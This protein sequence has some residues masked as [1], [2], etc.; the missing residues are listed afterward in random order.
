MFVRILALFA[1]LASASVNAKSATPQMVNINKC[2]IIGKY[3][4]CLSLF[5]NCAD[6]GWNSWNKFACDITE[7]LIKATA[8]ALVDTGLA[9]LGYNYVNLDDCWQAS[10]RDSAGFI[11]ADSTRF[12][13]GLKSLGDYIHAKGL[14][15]GIYSSAGFKT[16]Q[17]FPASLGLEEVDA[18]SYAAWGVDY[19]KYD[20]CYQDNGLPPK[21][22][23]AM[24]NALVGSG[25]EVFYSLCEWGR[26]NPAAWAPAIGADSWRTT[27]DIKDEWRS[28]I[29]RA[30][31][32]ASLWR[33]S[34]PTSGWNDPDMLEVGNGGCSDEEYRTHF[35]LWA[36]LKAPMIIGNDIRNFSTPDA[37]N[38]ATMEIL[39]NK[40]VLAVSQDALGRQARITWSDT[41][42]SLKAS[43]DYGDK[44]IATKCASGT[45]GAYEDAPI[46]QEW[47]FEA[48]GTIKSASTG[49]CLNEMPLLE[50]GLLHEVS[51]ADC[52]KATKWD[53]GK[54]MGGSIVSRASKKCLEVAKQDSSAV[55]QGKRVQTAPCQNDKTGD[56]DITEHQ[57]W[58]KPGLV[59]R[60][61]YQRSCLTVDRD[62]ATGVQQEAWASPLSDGALAVLLVN[63]GPSAASMTLSAVVAGISADDETVYSVR[64]LWQH[65]DL[66]ETFSA[67]GSM[68]FQVNSHGVV[69]LKLTP[70]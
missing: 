2:L 48:D 18:A 25:R 45:S 65:A 26:E 47:S 15:F 53:V 41:S 59:M 30:E 62:A 16:C 29:E 35:S 61:L 7:D 3:L 32:T 22:Y 38:S 27:G 5:F 21:R 54:Y 37:A 51:T 43:E 50:P 20:N 12:P 8:D 23:G 10:T 9:S 58:T 44:L 39:G 4:T 68:Q 31:I 42:V 40:D 56:I 6:Q 55:T 11:Q 33:Y 17:A 67:S 19:L 14:K 64:D 49:L 63:K 69:M 1:I 60:N 66:S 36:M 52:T 28:I 34:G 24:H 57:S 46:D 13:S 70:Q